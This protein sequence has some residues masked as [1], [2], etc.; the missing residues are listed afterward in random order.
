MIPNSLVSIFFYL[1][2]KHIC[3]LFGLRTAFSAFDNVT[4]KDKH[5]ALAVKQLIAASCRVGY[6]C[7]AEVAVWVLLLSLGNTPPDPQTRTVATGIHS[8][9]SIHTKCI[10]TPV[11]NQTAG[12]ITKFNQGATV[13]RLLSLTLFSFLDRT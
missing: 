9:W 5:Q 8:K 12:L 11:A 13:C 7:G 3:S 4:S 2:Y 6:G 10:P 1:A